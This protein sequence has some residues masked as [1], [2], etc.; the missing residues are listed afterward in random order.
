MNKKKKKTP[1]DVKETEFYFEK[2]LKKKP[3]TGVKMKPF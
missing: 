3:A 2:V 1:K